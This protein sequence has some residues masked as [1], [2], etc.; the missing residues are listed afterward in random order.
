MGKVAFCF[1]GQG[2]LEAGMGRELAEAVPAAWAQEAMPPGGLRWDRRLVTVVAIALQPPP[3]TEPF[4]SC[5]S[6]PRS[7]SSSRRRCN[8]R[9]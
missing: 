9:L 5:A 4:R 8:S 3:D 2:A 7:R 6:T 1:P